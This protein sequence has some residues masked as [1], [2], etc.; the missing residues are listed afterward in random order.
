[1]PGLQR[2]A[3]DLPD[4]RGRLDYIA[5]KTG[6]AA[7]K[8]LNAVELAK[9]EQATILGAVQ[10]IAE[11]DPA[12]AAGSLAA[13]AAASARRADG[14]LTDI[15]LAQDFHD[16]TGQVVARSSRW[17][18]TRGQPVRLLVQAAPLEPPP[19]R[20]EPSGL[21]GPAD[22]PRAAAATWSPT[23]AKWTNCSP[24]S[25]SE[26]RSGPLRLARCRRCARQRSGAS[27]RS[28][29]TAPEPTADAETAGQALGEVLA[30]R[31]VDDGL[32]LDD[33]AGHVVEIAEVVDEPVLHR[34]WPFQN[35][36]EK[37]S[38]VTLRRSPR[39]RT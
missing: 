9:R 32:G 26:R 34:R 37:V 10:R 29:C 28:A 23:S 14:Q 22:R 12:D 30:R 8:V 39:P 13:L 1:M 36:P 33:L 25:G 3:A 7:D 4:A 5:R 15:M 27:A 38:G 17:P 2:S 18:S 24:A 20:R 19:V 21:A 6:E 35:S 11:G 31:V 16:L